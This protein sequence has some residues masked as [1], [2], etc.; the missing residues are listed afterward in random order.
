[1]FKNR[2]SSLPGANGP[3]PGPALADW[4]HTEPKVVALMI[5]L[6]FEKGAW[7]ACHLSEPTGGAA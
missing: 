1:M 6:R 4:G 7:G 3:T 2:Q 5:E